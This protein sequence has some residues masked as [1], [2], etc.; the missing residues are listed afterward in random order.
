MS[1]GVSEC[2]HLTSRLLPLNVEELDILTL[3]EYLRFI[4]NDPELI[5]HM[6]FKVSALALESWPL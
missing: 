6:A 5:I 3:R 1:G 4:I 2:N